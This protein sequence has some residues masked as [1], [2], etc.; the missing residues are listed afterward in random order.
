MVSCFFDSQGISDRARFWH[1]DHHRRRLHYIKRAFL[2]RPRMWRTALGIRK[3]AVS[4]SH[5]FIRGCIFTARRYS[6]AVLAIALCV[7]PYLCPCPLQVGF[8]SKRLKESS[9]FSH[10]SFLPSILRCVVRKFGYI[11]NKGTF[12]KFISN[13]VLSSRSCCE[14]NSSFLVIKRT[15]VDASWL[16][17]HS[18]I[19]FGRPWCSN[20]HYFDLLCI[21]CATSLARPAAESTHGGLYV[22][23]LFL[24]YLFSFLT[25]WFLSGQL[26]QNLPG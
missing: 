19:D 21:C 12:W 7:C 25:I 26:S 20:L 8:L 17:A 13:S 3:I 18:L 9:W 1:E 5:S 11:Q 10:G 22:L 2:F 15:T 24:T 23:L 14:H 6:S 16:D 4:Y